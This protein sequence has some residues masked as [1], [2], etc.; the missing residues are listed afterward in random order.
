MKSEFRL[1]LAVGLMILVMVGTNILFPPLEPEPGAIGPD[2]AATEVE[3]A[4]GGLPEIQAMGPEAE[5]EQAASEEPA[6]EAVPRQEVVVEG[7]LYRY[8][9]D[10]YG[11]AATSV[12]LLQFESLATEGGQPVELVPEGTRALQGWIVVGRDTLELTRL[13]FTAEPAASASRRAMV[14][15][16]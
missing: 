7:P 1:L 16:P 6:V 11:A 2:S 9:F 4:A 10:N 14:R 3:P 8:T 13:G 5:V 15:R 12:Q